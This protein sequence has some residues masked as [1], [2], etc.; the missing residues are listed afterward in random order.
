MQRHRRGRTRRR[1]RFAQG[2][3]ERRRARLPVVDEP[4]HRSVGVAAAAPQECGP[5]GASPSGRIGVARLASSGRTASSI[6]WSTS[7]PERLA[8][9]RTKADRR[10]DRLA[11]GHAVV[12]PA[13]RQVQHVAGVEQP[14]VGRCEVGQDLQRRVG[15]QARALR[16]PD[17][18]APAA[19]DLQQED[20]VAVDVRADAAAVGR[21]RE[22]HI[23]ET[24]IGHEAEVA[25]QSVRASR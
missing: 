15:A 6:C 18:P 7:M 2:L 16:S 25:E 1:L 9:G 4:A 22:H 17:A 11:V 5:A 21:E 23:V 24:R 8:A 20:V 13:R 10:G 12:A 19:R 3:A 14:L